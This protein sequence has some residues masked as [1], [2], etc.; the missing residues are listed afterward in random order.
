MSSFIHSEGPAVITYHYLLI[1]CKCHASE[2]PKMKI[3][4]ANVPKSVSYWKALLTGPCNKNIKSPLLNFLRNNINKTF[5]TT[6]NNFRSL[7]TCFHIAD[8]EVLKF[9]DY[10]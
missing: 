8:D 2:L 3:A 4:N 5:T 6:G 9:G 1:W 7:R 10:R